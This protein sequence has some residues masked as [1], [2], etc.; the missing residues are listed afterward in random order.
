M[1]EHHVALCKIMTEVC[2]LPEGAKVNWCLCI[3]GNLSLSIPKTYADCCHDPCP[4]ALYWAIGSF[5]VPA[6]NRKN[7]RWF[8]WN[9]GLATRRYPK[10]S[11]RHLEVDTLELEHRHEKLK[12]GSGKICTPPECSADL[13]IRY[14]RVP[15]EGEGIPWHQ[16]VLNRAEKFMTSWHEIEERKSRKR[17]ANRDRKEQQN[18]K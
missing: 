11:K 10:R 1:V 16:G 3:T 17:A 5:A 9:D 4:L 14:L 2:H 6:Y 15:K 18:N 12:R 13:H 8:T 7:G